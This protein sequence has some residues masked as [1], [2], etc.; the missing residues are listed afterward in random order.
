MEK[1]KKVIFT[2]AA[3]GFGYL[4]WKKWKIHK[5]WWNRI[6]LTS[7]ILTE[8]FVVDTLNNATRHSQDI[9]YF[10]EKT[11]IWFIGFDCEWVGKNKTGMG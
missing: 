5:F 9:L 7:P 6:H 3:L 2:V 11:N 4:I 1:S 10:L 8:I